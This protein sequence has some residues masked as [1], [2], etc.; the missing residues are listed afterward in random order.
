MTDKALVKFDRVCEIL[1]KHGRNPHMLI[2]ILQEIQEEYKYLPEEIMMYIATALDISPAFAYGVAT[3]YSHFTLQPKGK[4]IIK[5]CDGTACHVKKSEEIINALESKLGLSKE[6]HTTDD[7][8]FTLET[9]ACLGACGIAPVVVLNDEVHG[10][11]NKEKVI[12]LIDKIKA[13]ELANAQS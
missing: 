9:V 1:D 13:E 4:N 10:A 6:K 12:S 3:F 5:V 8:L 11:M 7:T 2:K